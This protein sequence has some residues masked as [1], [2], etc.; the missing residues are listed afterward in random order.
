MAIEHSTQETAARE[1]HFTAATELYQLNPQASNTEL[2]DQL[3]ARLGQLTA[4]LTI[5]HGA[6]FEAF[7]GWNEEIQNNYLW[8][9]SMLADECHE[10]A[11]LISPSTD[12]DG[13]A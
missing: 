1:L 3:T 12:A 10:L 4:M 2:C 6:G 8:S 13:E 7:S 9:C 5:V 11:G